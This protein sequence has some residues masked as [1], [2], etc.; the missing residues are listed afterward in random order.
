M[1]PF[2]WSF[3]AQYALGVA[4]CAALYGYALYVQFQLGIEPCPLCIFQRVALIGVAVFFFFGA[5]HGP[6]VW[7][8][9]VYGV[10]VAL[11]GFAGAGIAARH[12]WLQHLPK[13]QVPDCGPGLA[14]MLDAFPLSKTV[15][16]VF[17]GSGEC[18]EVNW[19]FLGLSM[20]VWTLICFVGLAIAALWSAWRRNA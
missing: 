2:R 9:K 5:L 16:M 8:R 19:T 20:P 18:A 10:L 4:I 15:K 14:Y 3:R 6:K 17:T 11:A 13:G 7:G 12:I 1:N